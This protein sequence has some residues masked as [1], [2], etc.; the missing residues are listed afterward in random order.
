MS[1]PIQDGS[2]TDAD[3]HRLYYRK[4]GNSGKTIIVLHGGP[5]LHMNYFAP[6][7]EPLAENHTLIFYDQR[8]CGRSELVADTSLLTADHNVEDLE[9]LRKHFNIEKLILLGHSWGSGLAA[10]YAMK[11]PNHLQSMLLVDSM[12]P[13][14]DPHMGIFGKTLRARMDSATLERFVQVSEVEMQNPE[15]DRIALFREY[16]DLLMPS[17]VYD[18]SSADKMRGDINDVPPETILHFGVVFGAVMGSLG[19]FDWRGQLANVEIPSYVIHGVQDPI[20]LASAHEWAEVLPNSQ[21]LEI[22]ECGHFP[23]FE[24]PDVFFPAVDE[25]L[26]QL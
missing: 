16:F 10:L 26:Y 22:G 15:N 18:T 20:P 17:Y 23:F 12:P 6:D 9:V 11:Y 4:M 7:M 1:T 3:G 8:S 25:Y 14:A 21:M 24:K 19:N 13:R 2:F 5:G